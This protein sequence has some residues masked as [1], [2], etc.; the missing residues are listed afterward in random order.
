MASTGRPG[1]SDQPVTAPLRAG[2]RPGTRAVTPGARSAPAAA[3]APA[4]S[5]STGP[6]V[7]CSIV[8]R[9]RARISSAVTT[10]NLAPAVRTDEDVG[11]AHRGSRLRPGP[12][13]G[14]LHLAD[15]GGHADE[16]RAPDDAV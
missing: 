12:R 14:V 15:G 10:I 5:I 16:D 2:A 7:P 3:P 6:G 4:R 9:P 13:D 11:A 8:H 1:A